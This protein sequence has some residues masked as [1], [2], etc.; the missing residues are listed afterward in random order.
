M[1]L[2]VETPFDHLSSYANTGGT[3]I[4]TFIAKYGASLR[5]PL[6]TCYQNAPTVQIGCLKDKASYTIINNYLQSVI[7]VGNLP[8]TLGGDHRTTLHILRAAFVQSGLAG[9][10]IL[11]AHT[12]CQGLDMPL[13]NYNILGLVRKEFPS[14][15]M[16]LIGV[17]DSDV[18]IVRRQNVFDLIIDATEFAT[19]GLQGTLDLVYELMAG[20]RY[21][22]SIDL[23]VLDP[24]CFPCV[25]A[26]ISGG[27]QP[28]HLF[29][30]VKGL[31]SSLIAAD[32]VEFVAE[33]ASPLHYLLIADLLYLLT[34][35]S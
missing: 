28:L 18:Q 15:K 17:R 34:E 33:H 32:I 3:H 27:L 35:K 9:L 10:I 4:K 6:A 23:D 22:L 13:S 12:D 16:A 21:Y 20:Q 24:L 2:V 1:H 30:L 7:A 19:V 29:G 5:L 14:M 26:P 11:D 8:V 25:A 31:K